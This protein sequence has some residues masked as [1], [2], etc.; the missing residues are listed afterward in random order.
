[1]FTASV[2]ID[3]THATR[4]K[5]RNIDISENTIVVRTRVLD[6]GILFTLLI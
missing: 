4:S 1:M 3:M 6:I 2:A 5:C